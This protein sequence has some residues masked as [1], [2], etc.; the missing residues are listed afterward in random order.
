MA[1]YLGKLFIVYYSLI[2]PRVCHALALWVNPKCKRVC[3][4]STRFFEYH[5][6][7]INV[8]Y[9]YSLMVK[10]K[11]TDLFFPKKLPIKFPNS[12]EF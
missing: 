11:L 6:R 9:H 4:S 3:V 8:G 12:S 10:I 7:L 1:F 5:S 2:K